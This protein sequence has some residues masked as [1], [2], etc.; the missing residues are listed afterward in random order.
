MSEVERAV[1]VLALQYHT[2]ES[3]AEYGT[4]R[5]R[6]IV[7]EFDEEE[8]GVTLEEFAARLADAARS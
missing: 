6:V 2:P 8:G 7:G 4:R 3:L 1:R 5:L